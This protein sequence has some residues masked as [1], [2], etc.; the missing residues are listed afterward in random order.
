ML[1]VH[2]RHIQAC[3]HQSRTYKKCLCPIWLDWRVG[4]KRVQKPMGTADWQVA[5]LRAREIEAQGLQA[6]TVPLTL[7]QA[8]DRFVEDAENGRGLQEPTVRKYK[9]LFRRLNDHF[10]GKGYVF[11]NQIAPDDL[12]EFRNTWKM[13]P[14][15]AGKHIER[16]KTFFK[17]AVD[18]E[19]IRTNPA[20]PIAMPK[21]GDSDAVPFAEDQVETILTTCDVY[22]GNGKRLKALAELMLW[23]GLRVGDASTITHQAFLKDDAGWKV[24]LR[25]AKT[26]THVYCP[27]PTN[28]AKSIVCIPGK[29]P[30]WTGE[31]NAEDCAASWRKAFARLFKQAGIDGHIH[32]FRHTFAKR[33]L[34]SGTPMETV[35]Q[36]LGHRNIQVTQRSYN[37]WVAERQA[38][39]EA[40]VRN[41]WL[42]I[43][44]VRKSTAKNPHKH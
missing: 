42:R 24:R 5:Q 3:P 16:M 22:N 36:L 32:Q 13:S 38:D 37:K 2:R 43:G 19:W 28:V 18:F 7:K 11:L 6:N 29:H 14:R 21:V 33:L 39:L 35:S 27:I 17:Y 26:G 25:T 10:N 20:K 44:D 23:S 1:V 8:T 31:S 40:I 4:D 34:L 41:S 9:L 30:F 15:T 12:R